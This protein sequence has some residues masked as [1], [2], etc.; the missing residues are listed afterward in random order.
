M[1]CGLLKSM[2]LRVADNPE[3]DNAI[4]GQDIEPRC[5]GVRPKGAKKGQQCGKLLGLVL[6]R[7]WSIR[8]PRCGFVNN[9]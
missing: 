5:K 9:G 8:C 2:E 4:K 3:Y 1:D 6:T 7:P